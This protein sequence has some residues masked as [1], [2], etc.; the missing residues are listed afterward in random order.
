MGKLFLTLYAMIAI[1]ITSF[2]VGQVTLIEPVLKGPLDRYFAELSQG[3]MMLL[4]AALDSNPERWP[5]QLR[6]LQQ[7]SGYPIDM[8]RID[9]LALPSERLQRL[10]NGETL[11]E[12]I[13]SADHIYRRV[14]DSDQAWEIVLAET[15]SEHYQRMTIGTFYLLE[16]ALL[17]QPESAWPGVLAQLNTQFT[18][19]VSLE[20][21]DEMQITPQQRQ[22]LQAGLILTT[23]MDSAK[24]RHR[25]RIGA[26]NHI[27]TIG[28][29]T[30]PFILHKLQLILLAILAIV[31]ALAV[32][33][34]VRPLWHGLAQLRA[35]AEAFGRG[36]FAARTRI[37]PRA[38]LGQFAH[39]FNA[40]AD[41][42][43][44]LIASHKELT[45]AVSHE[46][47]TPLARLRFG[48]EM[49]QTAP[50]ASTRARHIDGMN[51]DIDE[52][53]G[54]IAELLT[55]ARFDRATPEL[56][57]EH[58][59]LAHWLNETANRAWTAKNDIALH[60]YP[61]HISGD[62]C[63]DFEPKLMARAL[64]N[65]LQNAQRYAVQRVELSS[66]VN[67][68]R[69][70]I[71]VDDDGPGIPSADRARIFE[72][73]TRLDT[74]RNRDSGGYGL[75]M[76]I[77]QRIAHWHGGKIAVEDSPLGGARFVIS[78][79]VRRANGS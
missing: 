64:G 8:R 74:S 22:R 1:A 66:D 54:L 6:V 60:I 19:P 27:L 34:W 77:A 2:M 24:E 7:A 33:V 68:D 63:T 39:A 72:P 41:R 30:L 40:M 61:T 38:A 21:F 15:K 55:Y 71:V 20:Y 59:D 10:R 70:R 4:D 18:F 75:G 73:F 50:D 23:D 53:E 67:A 12:K 17:Q 16:Q 51:T 47:R 44:Q 56:K 57:L 46:L 11:Y 14:K 65:V 35:T 58:Q 5:E 48:M 52:L 25:H 42:I 28:P 45:N 13:D 26:T 62:T 32:F 29:F 31:I 9:A 3:T 43:Q 49:L 36:D 79:P 78:W 37:A 69:C 76:A